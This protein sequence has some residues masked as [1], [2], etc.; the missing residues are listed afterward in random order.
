MLAKSFW[1][2]R[3][4][5]AL[6]RRFKI[7]SVILNGTGG[8]NLM[9]LYSVSCL[10]LALSL[11]PMAA[12]AQNGNAPDNATLQ[13]LLAEVR[14]LRMAIERAASVLP[15]TQVLLQRTQLQQQHVETLSRQ[16]EQLRD[17]ITKSSVEDAHFAAEVRDAETRASQEQDANRRREV[18]ERLKSAKAQMEQE[19]IHDQRQRARESQLAGQLQNEQSK[20]NEL[21]ERLDALERVL[22][23]PPSK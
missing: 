19:A 8:E 12:V 9:K 4:C 13:S 23:A 1:G 6:L 14:Q 21:Q 18:E 3:V 17:Q 5:Y 10:M 16:L 7:R 20:L 2:A 22:Q 11:Y 15:Q